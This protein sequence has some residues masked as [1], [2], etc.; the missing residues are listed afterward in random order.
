MDNIVIYGAGGHAKV[1]ADIIEKSKTYKI[2]GFLDDYKEPGT[3]FY[4]YKILGRADY[5]SQCTEDILGGI[6]ALGDNWLRKQTVE[7][8]KKKKPDFKFVTAIHPFASIGKGVKISEGSVVMAGVIINSDAI[9][10][11]HCIVNTKS[12]LGHDSILLDYVTIAPNATIAGNAKIGEC[13]TMSISS[14]IIH[15][16]EI[17]DHTVVG[18]GATVVKDIPSYTVAYG[19]P[20]KAIRNRK[21]KDSYL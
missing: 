10:G 9:V 3:T 15:G 12:S 14:T 18:A 8:I 17:G 20:A 7:M 4:G 6:V 5:I 11:E 13:S 2:L 19:T 1:V 16:K 21:E